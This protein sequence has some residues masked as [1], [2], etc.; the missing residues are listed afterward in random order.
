MKITR[1]ILLNNLFKIILLFAIFSCSY[2][3]LNKTYNQREYYERAEKEY[4][5]TYAENDQYS[6]VD[7]T[8][9]TTTVKFRYKKVIEKHGK[10]L[11]D[12]PKSS[13]KK[14]SYVLYV[15][16]L[17]RLNM[18][19]RCIGGTDKFLKYYPHDELEYE[20]LYFQAL[21]YLY[22]GNEAEAMRIFEKLQEMKNGENYLVNYYETL[23][24]LWIEKGSKTKA[25]EYLLKALNYA[26]TDKVIFRLHK[27]IGIQY[28]IM[29]K[30]E[31]SNNHYDTAVFIETI[32]YGDKYGVYLRKSDNFL[33]MKKEKES[34]KLLNSLIN[35]GNYYSYKDTI[36]YTLAEVGRVLHDEDIIFQGINGMFNSRGVYLNLDTI[37]S[38]TRDSLYDDTTFVTKIDILEKGLALYCDFQYTDIN[39]YKVA[40]Y[41]YRYLR[42]IFYQSKNKDFYNE[43]VEKCRK[44]IRLANGLHKGKVHYEE[45]SYE[46]AEYLLLE[47]GQQDSALGVLKNITND[48]IKE[49]NPTFYVKALFATAY[50]L[51]NKEDSASAFTYL[52]SVM[53]V[54]PY[55]EYAKEA[56]VI[57]GKQFLM[58]TEDSLNYELSL[59]ETFLINEEYRDALN[60]YTYIEN[61]E[62][63]KDQKLYYK[64]LLSKAYIYEDKIIAPDSA[65]IYYSIVDSLDFEDKD[66]KNIIKKKLK[67]KDRN[68]KLME[69]Q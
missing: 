47:L 43:R 64:S 29:K 49:V 31:V 28:G 58:N 68:E 65:F 21:S 2:S 32:A 48:S 8:E 50:I 54:L 55:S 67:D 24:D 44:I 20:M 6:K 25:M 34:V 14:S 62:R 19:E 9:L 30:F 33:Q 53:S 27:K 26:K 5:N 22:F 35:D 38:P 1:E 66:V 17:F 15:K 37:F 56:S 23:A 63:F 16:S 3:Y 41:A 13:F 40:L 60:K 57:L 61:E 52:D 36:N 11:K 42:R 45:K 51:L 10:L 12:H 69:I 4:Y 39:D 59:A 7:T 46:Y 18:W